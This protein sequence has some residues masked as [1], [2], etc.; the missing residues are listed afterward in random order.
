MVYSLRVELVN[1][2]DQILK[3]QGAPFLQFPFYFCLNFAGCSYIEILRSQIDDL[4]TCN[5]SALNLIVR[6][7][8]YYVTLRL[9]SFVVQNLK[10]LV[11][12]FIQLFL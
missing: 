4:D 1:F 7:S 5:S 3:K 2:A 11:A 12:I 6:L 10:L 8:I 9:M